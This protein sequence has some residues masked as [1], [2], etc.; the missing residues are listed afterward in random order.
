M[1]YGTKSFLDNTSCA[2][3]LKEIELVEQFEYRKRRVE[4]ATWYKNNLPY[5]SV[6]EK[7]MSMKDTQCLFN[8][9][10]K[11]LHFKKLNGINCLANDV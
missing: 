11:L 9:Q 4:I 6:P 8:L 2:V 10:I 5:K 7:I 1:G 3:L